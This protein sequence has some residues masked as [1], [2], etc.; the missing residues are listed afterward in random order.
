MTTYA[1]DGASGNYK[2]VLPQ[3]DH[4]HLAFL[5]VTV[6]G[7]AVP[8]AMENGNNANQRS[9]V[10]YAAEVGDLPSGSKVT[11]SDVLPLCSF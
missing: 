5:G 10:S 11:V 1:V 3:Q 6:G 9:L 4:D 7:T 8:F 2:F